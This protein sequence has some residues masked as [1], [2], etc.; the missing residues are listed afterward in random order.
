MFLKRNI[1]AT[2]ELHPLFARGIKNKMTLQ[3]TNECLT[4]EI[5]EK[6]AGSGTGREGAQTVLNIPLRRA[7]RSSLPPHTYTHTPPFSPPPHRW[8]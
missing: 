8:C 6:R 7:S 3:L 5:A 2:Q 1:K 4:A